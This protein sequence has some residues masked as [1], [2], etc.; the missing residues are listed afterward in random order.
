LLNF[1]EHHC[2]YVSTRKQVLIEHNVVNRNAMETL[3]ERIKSKITK[4]GEFLT[5]V[6]FAIVSD[7]ALVQCISII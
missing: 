1:K 2:S 3:F 6:Y 4:T 5:I 7:I